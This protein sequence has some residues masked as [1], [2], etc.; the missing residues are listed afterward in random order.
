M[1]VSEPVGQNRG[2]AARNG[3]EPSW[4][5]AQCVCWGVSFKGVKHTCISLV[6]RRWKIDLLFLVE[7]VQQTTDFTHEDKLVARDLTVFAQS[8]CVCVRACMCACVCLHV[9]FSPPAGLVPLRAKRKT[10]NQI[11]MF[12]F[13][14]LKEMRGEKR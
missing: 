1:L 13:Q 11:C 3:G 9:V 8:L 14:S 5:V 7:T 2:F 6:Q 12:S 4:C 10:K